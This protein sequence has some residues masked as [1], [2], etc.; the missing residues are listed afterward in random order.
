MTSILQNRAFVKS[1]SPS[2]RYP[3]DRFM[4]I[5]ARCPRAVLQGLA[6]RF[7]LGNL[8]CLAIPVR[9]FFRRLSHRC[10][11]RVV[12]PSTRIDALSPFGFCPSSVVAGVMG[13]TCPHY[14]SDEAASAR[15]S[16]EVAPAP[17]GP[18]LR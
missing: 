10:M 12:I 9:D 14:V 15:S 11:G 4:P 18:C 17:L 13:H 8:L 7:L 16:G 3:L 2:T 1:M 6:K 5:P